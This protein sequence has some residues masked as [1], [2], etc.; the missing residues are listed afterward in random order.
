MSKEK[1]IIETRIGFNLIVKR[2]NAIAMRKQMAYL[3]K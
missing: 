1:K 2:K 3:K